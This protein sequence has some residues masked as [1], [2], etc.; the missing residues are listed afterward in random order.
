MQVD[1]GSR[2]GPYEVISLLGHGG[3]GR[4]YLARDTRLNRNVALKVLAADRADHPEARERLRREARAIASLNHPHICALYDFGS[5][6]EFDY[7]VMEHLQGETLEA[8]LNRGPLGVNE[9]LDRAIE[10]A[11]AL[12]FAHR[13]GIVH[14]DLKP[15]NVMLTRSG[16]K[17]L[18]FGI[19]VPHPEGD[20]T[21]QW[22]QSRL[23]ATGAMLGTPRYMAPEQLHGRDADARTD[24]FAFGLLLFEALTGKSAFEGEGAVFAS[25]VLRDD[26]PLVSTLRPEALAL[27]RIVGR[28]LAKDPDDRWQTATDLL[29]ELKWIRSAAAPTS[30]GTDRTHPVLPALPAPRSPSRT[31]VLGAAAFALL[32]AVGAGLWWWRSRS[33]ADSGPVVRFTIPVD[34]SSALG[35]GGALGSRLALSSDGTRLVYVSEEAKGSRVYLRRIDSLQAAAIPGTEGAVSVFFA[36]DGDWVGFFANGK[37]KKVRIDGSQIVTICD[38]LEGVGASWG[39]DDT[40]VFAPSPSS[41]LYRVSS[42]GGMPEA[43]TTLAAGETSHRWPQILPGGRAVVF[44]AAGGPD[45]TGSKIA[46]QPLGGNRV[47]L[48]DGTYPHFSP[49]GHL[50]FAKDSAI[51]AVVFDAKSLAIHGNP[52]S[53]VSDLSMNSTTG[54]A[55]FDFSS[56]ATLVYR[57][58]VGAFAMRQMAWVGRDGNEESIGAEPRAFLQPRISPDGGRVAIGIG[59]V[60]ADRDVWLYDFARRTLTRLTF[61]TGEDETPSWSPDGSRIAI[62]AARPSR[63]RT[64]FTLQAAGGSRSEE[65]AT[66][67]R[68]THLSDW[69]PD[70]S[71]LAWTEF[72]PARGGDIRILGMTSPRAV[73]DFIVGPFN[74]RSPAFSRDGRWVAY[75]ST[76]TGRADVFV[77][78][79]SDPNVKWPIS[80]AGGSQPLWSWDGRELYYRGPTHMMAVP[81]NTQ[82]GFSAGT[83]EPLFLDKYEREHRDDRNYDVA[84]DGRFLMLKV[85]PPPGPPQLHVV[86]SWFRELRERVQ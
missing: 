21:R 64:I 62:S 8:R 6:D 15:A 12:D 13:A 49:T 84:R 63:P 36:P 47:D 5:L 24:L 73:R 54:A 28:L 35:F 27:D 43:V 74:E 66:T 41:A 2:V 76:E 57:A 11:E 7:L 4:V 39:R 42:K 80:T 50:V 70:G 77:R 60:A 18:D 78:S 48:T 67:Q 19:A 33:P 83:P 30:T 51:F 81:I 69:L 26:P 55:L 9:A 46:A 23:T 53:V 59:E 22:E 14:R 44:A 29:A 82:T 32:A 37:L 85:D 34:S 79:V 75:T 10:I 17:L 31:L 40:I 58:R 16:A 86:M 71:G 20:V 1:V 61:D 72:D 65:I 52:V 38:A 3:M 68:I 56:S 45:F 25:A